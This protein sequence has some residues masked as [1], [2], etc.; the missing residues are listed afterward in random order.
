MD[1]RGRIIPVIDLR[2]KMDLASAAY[3]HRTCIIVI[4]MGAPGE[5]TLMGVIVDGVSRVAD[6]PEEDIAPPPVFGG[7]S[8]TGYIM[9]MAKAEEGV[10]LLLD[11]EHI[12]SEG[13]TALSKKPN[14]ERNHIN[15][16]TQEGK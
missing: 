6:I 14:E 4:G 1:L 13:K 10:T 3:T 2:V 11:V 8:G 7:P 15:T 12:L 9:G 16:N 5:R